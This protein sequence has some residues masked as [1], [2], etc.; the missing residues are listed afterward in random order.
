[1][2]QFRT[3]FVFQSPFSATTRT[4]DTFDNDVINAVVLIQIYYEN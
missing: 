3:G 2:N 4:Q 1:M